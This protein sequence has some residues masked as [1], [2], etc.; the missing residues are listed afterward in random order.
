MLKLVAC[1]LDGTIIDEKGVCD[2][3]VIDA[4]EF[5]KEK[6]ILFV[7]CSGRPVESVLPLTKRWGLEGCFDYIVG[8]G[9]GEVKN[10]STGKMVTTYTLEEDVIMDIINTY[11][12]LGLVPTHYDGA[13]LYV[14]R[15]T[16]QTE[17]V[18]SR[19]N[20]ECYETD[21]RSMIKGPQIKHMM[22]I[23]PSEMERVEKYAREHP[24]E[25]YVSFKTANDLFEFNHRLL[26][27]DVGLQIISSQTGIDASEM[28]A[29]GDTTNDIE[30]LKYVGYGIAMENG[31]SDAK[32]VAYDVC[33]DIH[34]N[35]FANYVRE[36]L[37]EED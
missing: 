20:V 15:K 11:E 16:E 25:R 7:I 12:P 29:F 33:G 21:I 32:A 23:D 34:Q 27:K 22:I 14:E 30:M 2:K 5:L 28:M 26:A 19:V 24:D 31:T 37:E 10:M 35:G 3:S 1:D 36:F 9:G 13:T 6:D 18:V 4:I 17:K 8:S